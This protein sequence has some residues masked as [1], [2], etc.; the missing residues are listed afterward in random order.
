MGV[1][2]VHVAPSAKIQLIL[3]RVTTVPSNYS[4]PI[5]HVVRLV[6]SPVNLLEPAKGLICCSPLTSRMKL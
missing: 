2:F 6:L 1:L 5:E 3:L 4:G